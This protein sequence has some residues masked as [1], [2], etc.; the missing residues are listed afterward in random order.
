VQ[1]IASNFDLNEEKLHYSS[2]AVYLMNENKFKSE[3]HK[4][5]KSHFSVCHHSQFPTDEGSA[6]V[7]SS[8]SSFQGIHFNDEGF[9]MSAHYTSHGI[10]NWFPCKILRADEKD[11]TFD[12]V[13]FQ[14]N[15]DS[16]HVLRRQKYLNVEYLKFISKPYKGDNHQR[17]AFR[18]P[19]KIPDDVF[20]PVWMDLSSQ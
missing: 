8:S 4:W 15:V 19:I 3:Y 5:S 20:P 12:V 13:F 9:E 11:F 2:K 7:V 18:H 14:N 10:N 6:I 16:H 1:R 17:V